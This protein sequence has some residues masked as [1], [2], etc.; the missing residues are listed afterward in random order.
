MRILAIDLG[1]QRTGLALA[2][3]VTGIAS[4][5]GLVEVPIDHD[6]GK[7]LIEALGDQIPA[8]PVEI[9]IIMGMPLNMDDT[10]GPRAVLVK[11]FAIR[12]SKHIGRP[13]VL[14]DERRTS[15]AADAKMSQTGLTHKQKKKRRDAIAAAAIAEAF[16]A[17]P[18]SIIETITPGSEPV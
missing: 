1:D 4:P 3:R 9:E 18:D 11:E 16:L 6:G 17:E 7:R 15:V 8:L 12:L 5:A 2:D 14:V 13:I 10:I